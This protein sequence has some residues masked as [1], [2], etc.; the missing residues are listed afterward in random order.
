MADFIPTYRA[1]IDNMIVEGEIKGKPVEFVFNSFIGHK[2]SGAGILGGYIQDPMGEA[3]PKP[4]AYEMDLPAGFDENVRKGGQF[5]PTMAAD[6]IQRMGFDAQDIAKFKIDLPPGTTD[7][8]TPMKERLAL[9]HAEKIKV[10]ETVHTLGDNKTEMG[11]VVSEKGRGAFGHIDAETG[12]MAKTMETVGDVTHGVGQK[13][14]GAFGLAVG[15]FMGAN[16]LLETG[17]PGKAF[18]ATGD[19]GEV[20]M[21]LAHGNYLRAAVT[22]VAAVAAVPG[23]IAGGAIGS[24][25]PVAGTTVGAVAGSVGAAEAVKGVAVELSSFGSGDFRARLEGIELPP[26]A[27]TQFSQD[28]IDMVGQAKYIAHM[29]AQDFAGRDNNEVLPDFMSPEYTALQEKMMALDDAKEGFENMYGQARIDMTLNGLHTQ[30]AAAET[31]MQNAPVQTAK[32]DAEQVQS[33]STSA[34]FDM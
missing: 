31:L 34:K 3:K 25:V 33:F 28:F 10:G 1:E 23:G 2:E 26:N 22:G 24:V 21:D 32:F 20:S 8:E 9:T 12:R 27:Q 16:V 18:A 15:A 4:F 11:G 13:L 29:E 6:Q 30:L 19:V 17:D 5:R 14:T 7:F